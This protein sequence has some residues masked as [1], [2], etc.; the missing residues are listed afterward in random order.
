MENVAIV[1][2]IIVAIFGCGYFTTK[3]IDWYRKYQYEKYKD[4]SAEFIADLYRLKMKWV[5]RGEFMYCKAIDKVIGAET[6]QYEQD[7]GNP[8]T[9]YGKDYLL[10][11]KNML[12]GEV[13]KRADIL[14]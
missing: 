9:A 8:E 5:R 11:M 10:Q 12:D 6:E 2:L 1:A 13:R 4:N 14:E 7:P 3:I